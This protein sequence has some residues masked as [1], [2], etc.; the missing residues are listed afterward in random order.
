[1]RKTPSHG[2]N[3]QSIHE[4]LWGSSAVRVAIAERNRPRTSS[5]KL[6][7]S[8]CKGGAGGAVEGAH[9]EK[10]SLSPVTAHA[11]RS[12]GSS[13]IDLDDSLLEGRRRA[14]LESAGLAAEFD[15][16]K[17]RGWLWGTGRFISNIPRWAHEV[18][19]L[20]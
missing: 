18:V 14:V 10:N 1:M 9:C 20:H 11:R 5:V 7:S 19:G 16:R 12:D 6:Y 17:V 15:S 13:G 3:L 2:L 8:G 4:D